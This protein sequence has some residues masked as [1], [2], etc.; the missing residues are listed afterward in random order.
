MTKRLDAAV[1]AGKLTAE[2][3]QKL[4]DGLA[5]HIDDFVN[6]VR[7]QRGF[8]RVWKGDGRA[9]RSRSIRPP[10]DPASWA[11]APAAA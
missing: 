1:T 9:L 6:G 4:L 2:Q 3:K 7:K 5:E 10:A 11:P 8:H